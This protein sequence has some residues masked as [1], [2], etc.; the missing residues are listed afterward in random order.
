M[1]TGLTGHRVL[2]LIVMI[3][4][5]TCG[6]Y[7]V[8]T[9][10]V[11]AI[12]YPL[13]DSWIHQTFARN[14]AAGL[15]L[16]YNPG[17]QVPASTSPLWTGLVAVG[18][19]V[20]TGPLF[21]TYAMG[22]A[23]IVAVGCLVYFLFQQMWPGRNKLAATAA[24]FAA[25]EWRVGWA[26]MSGMETGLFMALSLSVLVLTLAE[27]RSV[28]NS[29]SA[30]RRL[31][32]EVALGLAC[33]LLVT[34][35]PEGVVLAGLCFGSLLLL[36]VSRGGS[37]GRS[38]TGLAVA[39]TVTGISLIPYAAFNWLMAGSVLP[40]TFNAKRVAYA[41]PLSLL[42]TVHYLRDALV[43]L[44]AGQSLLLVPGLLWG[45]AGRF[46]NRFQIQYL[47]SRKSSTEAVVVGLPAVWAASLVV[48][49]SFL[50][51]V[52]FH[53][54]RYLQP[55]VPIIVIYGVAGSASVADQLKRRGFRVVSRAA[56]MAVGVGV[57]VLWGAGARVYS[58]DVMFINDEQVRTAV[59]ISENT[60]AS[61]V[62]ATHDIGAIGYYSGRRLVDTAGLIDPEVVPILGNH[63]ALLNF[64]VSEGAT[65]FA[66]LPDWYPDLVD[67][68]LLKLVFEVDQDY[69]EQ[70]GVKNMRVYEVLRQ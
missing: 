40:T 70:L 62:V 20:P 53:H 2:S 29:R 19:L 50:L 16:S 9:A 49:Y 55:L 25:L 47:R 28:S 7:L 48:L 31:S 56:Y 67:S 44:F 17:E 27:A 4:L 11:T 64:A 6:L 42:S 65:Y 1:S 37:L 15:G 39:A 22:F 14:L 61:A 58:Q 23:C 54:G 12:G 8:V 3:A 10:R 32:C 34:T 33:G 59:W 51:P 13:D 21:W 46:W 36:A 35:R 38:L 26:C 57:M 41:Q 45:L 30:P 68:P 69:V 24:V 60:P 5:A 66:M 18:Y 52:V 63:L 43:A